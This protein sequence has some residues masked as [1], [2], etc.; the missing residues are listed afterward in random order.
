MSERNPYPSDSVDNHPDVEPGV[1][2]TIPDD[3]G[4]M[5]Q[6]V[7]RLAEFV[8]GQRIVSAV[9]GQIDIGPGH[10]RRNLSGLVLT[11][12]S[13]VRV[14]LA[15]SGECCAHTTLQEFLLHPDHVDHV[16]TGCASTDG[17]T[18]WHIFADLG[19]VLEL[20][21]D[22]SAGNPFYYGYGFEIEVEPLAVEWEESQRELPAGGS[23]S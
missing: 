8:V 6:N 2:Y 10:W 11:L 21:V 14:V 22:W 20:T 18:K 16:I 5:P 15:D 13:G 4:T 1:S 19:D 3:D 23:E 7:E 12:D 9:K 17:Y